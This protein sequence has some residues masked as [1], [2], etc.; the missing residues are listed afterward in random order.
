MVVAKDV[1][2]PQQTE[3]RYATPGKTRVIET[4][5]FAGFVVAEAVEVDH[6]IDFIE[7]AK[8]GVFVF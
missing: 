7:A 4:G 8:P 6:F 3:I 2:M 1:D 5:K